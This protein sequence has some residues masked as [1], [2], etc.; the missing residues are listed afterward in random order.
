MKQK[1]KQKKKRRGNRSRESCFQ[2]RESCSLA[3]GGSTRVFLGYPAPIIF[4]SHLGKHRAGY[5]R[6]TTYDFGGACNLACHPV[7]S[8]RRERRASVLL[9]ER[10]TRS[11]MPLTLLLLRSEQPCS[12]DDGC[13]RA[14]TLRAIPPPIRRRLCVL[15]CEPRDTTR[16]ARIQKNTRGKGRRRLWNQ[17]ISP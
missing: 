5:P 1:Q 6:D 15:A 10:S 2:R 14:C 11:P 12:R 16:T 9:G 3:M 7:S 17:S 13:C 4:L 8:P